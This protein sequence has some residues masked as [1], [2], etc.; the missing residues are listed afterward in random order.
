M[1]A[2]WCAAAAGG[3]R[4]GTW[5]HCP[6]QPTG[7]PVLLYSVPAQE[8]GPVCNPFARRNR[9]AA[10]ASATAPR[11]AVTTRRVRWP[12]AMGLAFHLALYRLQLLNK[13]QLPDTPGA[14][15][16]LGK[17]VLPH[18][19]PPGPQLGRATGRTH[20]QGQ[21]GFDAGAAASSRS[22]C[23]PR[24]LCNGATGQQMAARDKAALN[25]GPAV[26][27]SAARAAQPRGPAGT[28]ACHSRISAHRSEQEAANPLY[29]TCFLIV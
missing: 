2:P 12:E 25:L 8:T 29:L 23:P 19:P 6:P 5:A 22:R 16:R 10:T 21:P 14:T 24:V 7:V 20:P 1:T 26:T 28:A 17:P 27:S 15:T 4:G 11:G 13:T 9:P 3:Q 18:G